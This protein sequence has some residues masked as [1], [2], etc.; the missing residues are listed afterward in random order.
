MRIAEAVGQV[1]YTVQGVVP[2]GIALLNASATLTSLVPGAVLLLDQTGGLV[3]LGSRNSAGLCR[4]LPAIRH[5]D[6]DAPSRD[7]IDSWLREV[8][9]EVNATIRYAARQGEEIDAES[10]ILICGRAAHRKGTDTELA[11]LLGRPVA[12]WR[13][14]GRSRPTNQSSIF[15]PNT[16]DSNMAV[17]L[18]LACCGLTN[19]GII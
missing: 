5:T 6:A 2:H 14:A 4:N 15:D 17:S 9:G 13:Y 3:S 10:P 1:G 12:T 7:V 19:R 18:S 16:S 8:A 11:T